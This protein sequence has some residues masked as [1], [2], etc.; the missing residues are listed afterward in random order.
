MCSLF[1]NC[2]LRFFMPNIN[3]SNWYA[4]VHYIDTV[5]RI[6]W[7]TAAIQ[8]TQSTVRKKS[9]PPTVM[10][11]GLKSS[12]ANF[13]W[14]EC[15]E[16]IQSEFKCKM[17]R[18]K[19]VICSCSGYSVYLQFNIHRNDGILWAAV[20]WEF[21]HGSLLAVFSFSISLTTAP[22]DSS[23]VCFYYNSYK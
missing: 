6:G 17:Q 19:R 23:V 9:H 10:W 8:Q 13:R 1:N 2:E 3:L 18:R 15:L 22:I 4:L 12:P 14:I 20:Y 5:C 21:M 7:M 16:P 11:S